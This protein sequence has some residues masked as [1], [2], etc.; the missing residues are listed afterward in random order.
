MPTMQP[1]ES[2]SSNWQSWV[3]EP[4][5]KYPLGPWEARVLLEAAGIMASFGIPVLTMIKRL[6]GINSTGKDQ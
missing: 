3:C 6:V 2:L 4:V 1:K 5:I